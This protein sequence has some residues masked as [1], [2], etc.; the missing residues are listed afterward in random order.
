ME[1]RAELVGYNKSYTYSKNRAIVG[2]SVDVFYDIHLQQLNGIQLNIIQVALDHLEE[3]L[4]DDPENLKDQLQATKE[5]KEIFKHVFWKDKCS[6]C[7]SK[8][9]KGGQR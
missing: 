4:Q 2:Y 9:K 1:N 6:V 3:E 5:V 8:I 7:H